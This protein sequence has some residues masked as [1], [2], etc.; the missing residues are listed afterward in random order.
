MRGG[1][2][3]DLLDGD[4][5]SNRLDGG[6]GDDDLTGA[7]GT[8]LGG[9]GRD[10]FGSRFTSPFGGLI[11]DF[12]HGVDRLDLGSFFDAEAEEFD[13]TL[14][15]LDTNGNARLDDGDAPVNVR[16]ATFDG[17]SRQSLHVDASS[18]GF[19]G[20]EVT[21]FGL[22][23]LPVRDLVN[24]F[25]VSE[26]TGGPDSL[27]GDGRPDAIFGLGGAD[28][29]AG[30]GGDDFLDGG[31]G[32]DRVLGEAGA[33]ELS[34]G[35]GADRV[36]GG[37]GDDVLR[38]GG[39]DDEVLG[40]AGRDRPRG[41]AGDD[42]IA[43]GPGSDTFTYSL[44]LIALEDG[45]PTDLGRDVILDFARGEDQLFIFAASFGRDFA[46]LELLDSNDDG[47]VD[48]RDEEVSLVEVG[49][50]RSLSLDVS[51]LLATF[52]PSDAE[53]AGIGP[54]DAVLTIAGVTR[55]SAADFGDLI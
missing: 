36:K 11:V 48:T 8:Y 39:G 12:E 22:T 53:L 21:L 20:A 47:S 30:A 33:D 1:A 3:D 42:R 51:A 14:A 9:P 31:T 23:Q 2:G 52:D 6:P 55:L 19:G 40:G 29:L 18:L 5:G 34:G 4:S 17:V 54:G 32:A 41:D 45:A 26:G 25:A 46:N 10:L 15:D 24:L 35:D 37:A 49:G 44:N 7:G 43:G 28:R 38:G 16:T 50:A 27:T 13:F